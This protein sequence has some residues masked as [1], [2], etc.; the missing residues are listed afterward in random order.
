MNKSPEAENVIV[1]SIANM[2]SELKA[3]MLAEYAALRDELLTRMRIRHQISRRRAI[4]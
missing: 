4:R 2:D 1:D 3:E